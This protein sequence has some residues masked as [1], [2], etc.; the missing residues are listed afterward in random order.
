MMKMVTHDSVSEDLGRTLVTV[1][2]GVSSGWDQ[3][4]G[5]SGLRGFSEAHCVVAFANNLLSGAIQ[6]LSQPA[7]AAHEEAGV[8]VEEDDGRVAVGVLPVGQKS[9]LEKRRNLSKSE[10]SLENKWASQLQPHQGEEGAEQ[11][12]GAEVCDVGVHVVVLF[13]SEQG[14]VALNAAALHVLVPAGLD[15]R[16]HQGSLA[17]ARRVELDLLH[18]VL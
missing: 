7:D 17:L 13:L 2:D 5:H 12:D 18:L 9:G 4:K 16:L 10:E 15:V 6:K 3:W 14:V 8:D 11:R 1:R